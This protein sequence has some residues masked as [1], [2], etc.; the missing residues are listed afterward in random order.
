MGIIPIVVLPRLEGG[1]D[2]FTVGCRSD[3]RRQG[4]LQLPVLHSS[5]GDDVLLSSGVALNSNKARPG[6]EPTSPLLSTF[7][8]V[9]PC[10]SVKP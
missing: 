2:S 4:G 9:C 10:L 7:F 1:S 6:S 3:D 5:P 8:M